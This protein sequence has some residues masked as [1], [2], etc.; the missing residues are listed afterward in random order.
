MRSISPTRIAAVVALIASGFTPAGIAGAT[1]ES[2]EVERHCVVEVSGVADGVLVAGQEVCF[3]TESDAA[4][5]AAS[6]GSEVPASKRVARSSGTNTIGMHYTSQWYSG[7]SIRVVGTS[8]AGGVWYPTG[9]W[10]NNIESSR[11]YCGTRPT[12]FY[13]HSTCANSPYRIYSAATSLGSMNNRA[14]CVRYG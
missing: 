11:H 8:C 12:S 14:S 9:T 1:P 4:L 13:D 2:L 7:S 3:A 10:N 6:L 5:H